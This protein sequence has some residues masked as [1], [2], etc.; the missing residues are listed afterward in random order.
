[1][2]GMLVYCMLKCINACCYMCFQFEIYIIG[3]VIGDVAAEAIGDVAAEIAKDTFS[4]A[5][6]SITTATEPK[7]E[8]QV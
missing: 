4:T 1:M 2:L 5:P 7:A 8:D 3:L 6:F